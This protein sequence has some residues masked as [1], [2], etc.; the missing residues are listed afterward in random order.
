MYVGHFAIGLAVKARY[1][2]LPALPIMLGVASR[3][4]R[5]PRFPGSGFVAVVANH[6]C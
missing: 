5:H 4:A 3:C 1:P 6:P 2:D